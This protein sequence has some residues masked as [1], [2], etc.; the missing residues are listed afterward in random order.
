MSKS[1]FVTATLTLLALLS[2]LPAP[3]VAQSPGLAPQSGHDASLAKQLG[4]DE[5]GMRSYVLVLLRSSSRPV[6]K[7]P[8]RDAM[9]KAHLANIHRLASTG[10][11]VLAGPLDGGDGL[12]GL[13]VFAV[14]DVDA[15]RELVAS[16][17][18]I[19]RGEMVA[20]YHDFYG[21]AAIMQINDLHEHLKKKDF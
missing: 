19:T 3:G 1:R 17:P 11:L 14:K 4:A 5:Y 9:F 16:D 6:P 13:F 12:R 10:K 18:V 21:S 2:L 7:G 8:E 20:E 15:A